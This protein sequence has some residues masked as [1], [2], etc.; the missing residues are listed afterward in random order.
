VKKLRLLSALVAVVVVPLAGC[1]SNTAIEASLDETFEVPIH[2]AAS[3][4]SENLLLTF[5]EVNEDSRCP[6]GVECV[7]PGQ[8]VY[9][10]RFT[11]GGTGETVTF[12]EPGGGGQATATFLDYVVTAKLQPYPDQQAE[13]P[14]EDYSVSPTVSRPPVVDAA[15]EDDLAAIYAAVIRRL[16]TEDNGNGGPAMDVTNLYLVYVTRD[17]TPI[18]PMAAPDPHVLPA[19]LRDK[20]TERLADLSDSINWVASLA[21]LPLEGIGA[22]VAGGGAVVSLGNVHPAES[23]TWRLYAGLYLGNLNGTGRVYILGNADGA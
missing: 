11:R 23:G 4:P 6:S 14:P 16:V 7:S 1:A 5:Q 20:I 3:L 2:R 9:S 12:V 22:T 19:T 15:P 13:F 18:E 21:N 17:A 8:A 10:V